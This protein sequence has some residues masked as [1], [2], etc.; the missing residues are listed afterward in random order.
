MDVE[1]NCP[2]EPG[3][4]NNYDCPIVDSDGDGISDP[5]DRC[6]GTHIGVEVD[7]YGCPIEDA[8]S[9]SNEPEQRG[10]D[11]S[12]IPDWVLLENYQLFKMAEEASILAAHVIHSK[13]FKEAKALWNWN[14][15]FKED[16]LCAGDKEC[17]LRMARNQMEAVGQY[18]SY[19]RREK[20]LRQFCRENLEFFDLQIILFLLELM[21]D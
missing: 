8:H 20:Q 14:T 11:Y 9:K 7:R 17:W 21:E 1:D 5:D 2:F 10:V 12:D 16:N 3:P 6:P 4:A 13:T 15:E 18:L 19:E